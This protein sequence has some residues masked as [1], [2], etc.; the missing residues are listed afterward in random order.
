MTTVLPDSKFVLMILI[1]RLLFLIFVSPLLCSSQELTVM[2]YNTEN[3]FDTIDDPHKSDNEFL[4]GSKLTWNSKKYFNKIRN[5]SLVIDSVGGP[6]FPA[7]VGL[8]EVENETCIKDLVNSEKLANV[9]YGFYVT[10]SPDV[11]SIDVALLY[12]KDIFQLMKTREISATNPALPENKTR[13]ILYA[14]LKYKKEQLHVFVNHWPSMRDG[15]EQ[16]EPR[17]DYAAKQLRHV[18]DSVL[19]NQPDAKIIV[20]GDF[21]ETPVKNAIAKTLSAGS[22]ATG[23]DVILENPFL[24]L[25][26][27]GEGTHYYNK[28][29]N[30]L[31]QVMI[32]RGLLNE[33]GIHYKK[34]SATIFKNDLVLYTAPKLK[35][36]LPN[37][38]FKGT[39]YFNGFSDHLPVYIKLEH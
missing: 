22:T 39:K 17:R 30:V 10:N 28:E 20:M 16:S 21:N 23:K 32:S 35:V 19:K 24:D 8:C 4:P 31:D 25:A 7:L 34:A 1:R 6:E 36:K 2:F 18:I 13:N 3:F 5:L 38:T 9:N 37:R 27:R 14:V 26:V 11:R 12:D 33:K 29:W 15:E